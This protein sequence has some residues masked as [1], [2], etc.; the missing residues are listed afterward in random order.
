[1]LRICKT[2]TSKEDADT[3]IIDRLAAILSARHSSAA[4]SSEKMG[5]AD[6]EPDDDD[7]DIFPDAVPM[8]MD[9][10]E[11]TQPLADDAELP[12]KVQHLQEKINAL[13]ENPKLH[14]VIDE[15]TPKEGFSLEPSLNRGETYY[16]EYFP[17][18][19]F[20]AVFV[21]GYD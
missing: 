7:F 21:N 4:M 13:I 8:Q 20:H 1:M 11:N 10:V 9:Y 19:V 2:R 18:Y 12:E 14:S 5:A 3:K 17:T 15:E 6:V 16:D